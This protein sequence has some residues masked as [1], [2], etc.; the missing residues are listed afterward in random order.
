MAHYAKVLNNKVIQV[1]TAEE[2]FFDSFIFE[3]NLSFFETKLK[4]VLL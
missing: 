2:D 1:I 4:L 3:N